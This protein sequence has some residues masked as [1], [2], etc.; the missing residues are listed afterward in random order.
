[1]ICANKYPESG[2]WKGKKSIA[3]ENMVTDSKGWSRECIQEGK[4]EHNKR[5]CP[6]QL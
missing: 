6:T 4:K 1:M 2:E 3:A 5:V